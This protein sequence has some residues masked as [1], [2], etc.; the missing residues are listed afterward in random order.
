MSEYLNGYTLTAGAAILV[1]FACWF[2]RAPKTNLVHNASASNA[3][4]SNSE[5][6]EP[7]QRYGRFP[8][9]KPYPSKTV[10]TH[11]GDEAPF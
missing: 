9:P 1:A 3:V 7:V 10:A 6:P 5:P 11:D 2:L 4:T 8:E